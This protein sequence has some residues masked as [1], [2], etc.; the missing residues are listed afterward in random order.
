MG[1]GGV[2]GRRWIEKSTQLA[3][4]RKKD[5]GA[6]HRSTMGKRQSRGNHSNCRGCEIM[7]FHLQ[8]LNFH[9]HCSFFM[10]EI[11]RSSHISFFIFSRY[12][13]KMPTN[14]GPITPYASLFDVTPYQELTL[15]RPALQAAEYPPARMRRACMQL[16]TRR[17]GCA[18]PAWMR[19]ACSWRSP[20]TALMCGHPRH[21]A[22]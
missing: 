20:H 7:I 3:R 11:F 19:R 5:L 2:F 4:S 10:F 9:F 8:F 16:S 21:L 12:V 17:H 18:E 1:R 6:W 13:N 15:P 14:R 22:R